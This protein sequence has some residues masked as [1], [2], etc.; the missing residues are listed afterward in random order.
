MEQMTPMTLAEAA[1]AQPSKHI[2]RKLLYREYRAGRFRAGKIGDTICTTEGAMQDWIALCLGK[3]SR[4]AS[5][6]APADPPA[7]SSETGTTRSAQ[8]TAQSVAK[9]LQSLDALSVG[10]LPSKLFHHPRQHTPIE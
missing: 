8:A 1:E 4:P 9:M 3:S 2:T 10:I 6:S 5:T 7:G